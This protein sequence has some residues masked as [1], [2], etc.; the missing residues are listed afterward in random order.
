MDRLFCVRSSLGECETCLERY[1]GIRM[2]RNQCDRCR[3]EVCFL[4]ATLFT[5]SD[6]S[7]PGHHRYSA[8]NEADPGVVPDDL[9]LILHDLTQ[10]E[11]MLCN[12]VKK[13]QSCTISCTDFSYC[14]YVNLF[15]LLVAVGPVGTRVPAP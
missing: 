10:M 3:C 9:A 1:H 5:S 2:H 12:C 4:C 11:D 8:E 7:Q 13:K 15:Q 14:M 6:G